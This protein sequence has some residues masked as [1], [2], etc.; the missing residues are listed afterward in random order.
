MSKLAIPFLLPLPHTLLPLSLLIFPF[1]LTH[2]P[3]KIT[4]TLR[5]HIPLLDLL[6]Y[7][8]QIGPLL[9]QLEQ[10]LHNNLFGHILLISVMR[11]ISLY[12]FCF[13]YLLTY[14]YGLFW[15]IKLLLNVLL[16]YLLVVHFLTHYFDVFC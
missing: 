8:F 16:Y 1:L 4:N 10:Y 3:L 11:V 14:T 7:F 5:I 13:L 6:Q 12:L 2:F 15:V 9:H